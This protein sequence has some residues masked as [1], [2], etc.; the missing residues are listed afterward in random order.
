MNGEFIKRDRRDLHVQL[1]IKMI[2]EYTDQFFAL[3]IGLI[4]GIRF[5]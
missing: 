3:L 4:S 1:I 5:N 2:G